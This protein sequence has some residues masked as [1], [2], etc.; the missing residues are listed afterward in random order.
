MPIPI[1]IIPPDKKPDDYLTFA[2]N[3]VSTAT[4]ILTGFGIF[5]ALVSVF[6]FYQFHKISDIR[7]ETELIFESKKSELVNTQ[8]KHTNDIFM[9][10]SVF[11]QSSTKVYKDILNYLERFSQPNLGLT[12]IRDKIQNNNEILTNL[13]KINSD[14]PLEVLSSLY[15]I[16]S[17]KIKELICVI[18][19][20]IFLR[21][22]DAD[23]K[24]V[25]IAAK[26]IKKDLSK[27]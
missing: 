4:L 12:I 19:A 27:L 11:T 21:S 6:S 3:F 14:T 17:L 2:S 7:N 10:F 8:F 5:I 18:D 24:D 25:I 13:V 9:L 16:Q 23:F 15:A 22:N 1:Q 26:Q 20:L